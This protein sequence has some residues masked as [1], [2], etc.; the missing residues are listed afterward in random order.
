MDAAETAQQWHAD[1]HA[2]A[3]P[4]PCYGPAYGAA[5]FGTYREEVLP[6]LFHWTRSFPGFYLRAL[7][8]CRCRDLPI[9]GSTYL[10]PLDRPQWMKPAAIWVLGPLSEAGPW[11]FGLGVVVCLLRAGERGRS[12]CLT[13][14]SVYYAG[15]LF[16]VLPELKHAE[17]LVLPLSVFG[18]VGLASFRAIARPRRLAAMIREAWRPA[19]GL[20]GATVAATLAWGLACAVSYGFSMESRRELLAAVTALAETG[21]PAPEALRGPQLFS[22]ALL[23]ERGDRPTGY[24]LRIAAGPGPSRLE[25]RRLRHERPLAPARLLFTRHR[26]HPGREQCF[27]VTCNPGTAFGDANPLVCTA[28]LEGDARFVSCTRVDLS[29]WRRLPVATVFVPGE[30]EPGDPVVGG[31]T[32]VTQYGENPDLNTIGLSLDELQRLGMASPAALFPSADSASEPTAMLSADDWRPA[33]PDCT[34]KQIAD[35][36]RVWTPASPGA[37]AVETPPLTAP[38]DGT[39]Y[40]RLRYR[41]EAGRPTFGVLAEDRQSW[42][43]LRWGADPAGAAECVLSAKLHAGQVLSLIASNGAPREGDPSIFVLERLSA[44]SD[45][46]GD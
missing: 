6:N 42:L 17:P 31:A 18:G 20:A 44:C 2:G 3:G 10:P 19:L 4:V 45:P 14:F 43:A 1:H 22:A 9:N 41:C 29:E 38:A 28:L 11:L 46:S 37:Y 8:A 26:L 15:V 21:R 39:Y 34:T 36:L 13:A 16:F 40:F 5:C 27:F 35:G 25:C 33:S 23:P 24:L 30:C 7:D 12:L 32:S